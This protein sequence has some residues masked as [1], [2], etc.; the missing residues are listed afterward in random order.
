MRL[1]ILIDP[2]EETYGNRLGVILAP[3]QLGRA[4]QVVLADMSL[5]RIQ[6]G[7]VRQSVVGVRRLDVLRLEHFPARLRPALRMRQTDLFGV[8]G[9][10][11]ITVAE[12]HGA[13]RRRLAQHVAHL[14]GRTP[15]RVREADIVALAVDRREIRGFHLG[16]DRPAL[17]GTSS[18]ALTRLARIDLS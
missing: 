15:W 2:F 12:Q 13:I 8:T 1:E 7:D 3:G 6:R 9:V 5:G 14:L 10:S 16:P 18:I 4:F 17:N 11:S